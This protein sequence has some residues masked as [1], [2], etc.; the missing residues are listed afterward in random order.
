MQT[1]STVRG[2]FLAMALYPD[3]FK[4]A[5]EEID[6]VVGSQRLPTISDRSHLPYVN[7]L[8]IEL[9]RWMVVAPNGWCRSILLFQ[10]DI[11]THFM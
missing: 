2:F 5:Q 10:I 9:F 4:K 6:S 1:V 11:D 8:I 7:S 3:V